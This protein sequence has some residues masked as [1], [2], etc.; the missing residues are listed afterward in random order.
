MNLYAYANQNPVNF[1][2]PEGLTF[3][4]PRGFPRLEDEYR[5][6]QNTG[7]IIAESAIEQSECLSCVANCSL[8]VVV[9][10]KAQDA[11]IKS[12]IEIAATALAKEGIKN[13]IPVYNVYSA[14]S[15]AWG[16]ADCYLTCKEGSK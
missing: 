9:V 15:T 11:G 6:W 7:R 12:Y 4:L 3:F 14:V 5:A 2:D 10:S 1:I 8:K 16:V 13:A